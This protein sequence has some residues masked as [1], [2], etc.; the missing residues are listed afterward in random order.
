VN[1]YHLALVGQQVLID[2]ARNRISV[3][4]Q[5][6]PSTAPLNRSKDGAGK[7]PFDR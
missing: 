4:S 1:A 5:P 6:H 7:R 3:R 2:T